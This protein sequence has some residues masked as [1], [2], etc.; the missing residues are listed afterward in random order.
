MQSQA[1]CLML[2]GRSS[3]ITITL[4][5]ESQGCLRGT[6]RPSPVNTYYTTGSPCLNLCKKTY[7]L[8]KIVNSFHPGHAYTHSHKSS[9]H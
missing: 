1:G 7:C 8:K 4:T 6:K 9:S 2:H 3:W 5:S